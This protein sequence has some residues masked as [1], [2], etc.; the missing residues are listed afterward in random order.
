MWLH[1][2]DIAIKA[3]DSS[4]KILGRIKRIYPTMDISNG[5]V[6]KIFPDN[7]EN[8]LKKS[9]K[10][11]ECAVECKKHKERVNVPFAFVVLEENATEEEALQDLKEKS[12]EL[13]NYSRPYHFIFLNEIPKSS[14]GKVEYKQLIKLIPENY[15]EVIEE[16]DY[17]INKRKV[18]K[19]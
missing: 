15:E 9:Q 2:G 11:K 1:S 17:K 18:R 10:I 13:N 16:I 3:A 19:R 8:I 7:I 4:I 6:A 14:G 12:L 5:N